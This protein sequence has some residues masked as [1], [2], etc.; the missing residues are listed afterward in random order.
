MK[1]DKSDPY[2]QSIVFFGLAGTFALIFS[3]FHGGFQY[4]LT[5]DQFLLFIP[6]TLCATI[7]PVLLFRAFQLLD[8][9]ENTILQSSQKLWMVFGAFIFLKEPFS[10]QKI[11]GT[12]VIILGITIALWKKK[13]FKINNGVFLVLLATLFYAGM[14]LISYYIVRDF[15]AISF[16]VYVC[17][18]P[19]ITLLLIRPQ[20]IK[21]LAYY[22]K[23]K[24]ALCVTV[25]SLSDTVGSICTFYAYQIGRNVAQIAPLM[26]LITIISVILA[27]VF[28]KER[29]N[30]INK[31]IGATIVVM[32]A[33]LVL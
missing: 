16:I 17:Y 8:A 12:A 1:D 31:I 5:P 27:V 10:F 14:D 33:L 26:G 23:P 3:F 18:L 28:L 20:T 6:L 15:D 22:F 19:V 25:L 11:I 24:H 4:Q 29:A 9:S 32:G 30:L 7:G 13:K 21:K 2:A